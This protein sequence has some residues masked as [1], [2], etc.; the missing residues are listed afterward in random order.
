MAGAEAPVATSTKGS[1]A[2]KKLVTWHDSREDQELA[3]RA[4]AERVRRHGNREAGKA[5]VLV[6]TAQR[7]A[8]EPLRV[9]VRARLCY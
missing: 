3:Q 9:E 7:F 2:R 4:Q 1:M 5:E 6:S 8:L